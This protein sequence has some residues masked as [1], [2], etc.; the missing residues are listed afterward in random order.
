LIEI[1]E[2]EYEN[3]EK[4]I[5]EIKQGYSNLINIEPTMMEKAAMA[6]YLMSL[7]NGIENILKNLCKYHK[8]PLPKGEFY[9]IELLKLFSSSQDSILPELISEN[10]RLEIH[11]LRKF[12][13]IVRQG[14]A[15][16]FEWKR[17]KEGISSIHI[18]FQKFKQNLDNH[19]ESLKITNK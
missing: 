4:I 14:Y 16:N 7:Y 18:I 2:V 9:H 5:T 1:V 3:L 8:V 12:R 6:H 11:E 19:I 13:H 17:I 15:F 10:I